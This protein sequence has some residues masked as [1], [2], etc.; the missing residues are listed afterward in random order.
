MGRGNLHPSRR[1]G[2]YQEIKKFEEELAFRFGKR[3]EMNA[4][5]VSR[6]TECFP[7]LSISSLRSIVC[8]LRRESDGPPVSLYDISCMYRRVISTILLRSSLQDLQ[9]EFTSK[10]RKILRRWEEEARKKKYFQVAP[11]NSHS[12]FLVDAFR[13]LS[14][15]D[16]QLLTPELFSCTNSRE[17]SCELLSNRFPGSWCLRKSSRKFPTKKFP[18]P[19]YA[20]TF[21]KERDPLVLG[22]VLLA[23]YND[24]WVHLYEDRKK[25]LRINSSYK[26]DSFIQLLEN[27][28]RSI[29]RNILPKGE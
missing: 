23:R 22:H 29:R 14:P 26:S 16:F 24:S 8:S 10:H 1:T 2:G 9:G 7:S 19:L 12:R 4:P 3:C 28:S 15:G 11:R 17:L 18:V 27:I 20:L 13:N 21:V 5:G 25:T 6:S